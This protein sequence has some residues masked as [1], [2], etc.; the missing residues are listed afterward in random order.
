M[1]S[2]P[3]SMQVAKGYNAM[4]DI[5][6]LLGIHGAKENGEIDSMEYLDNT[7]GTSDPGKREEY[8]FRVVEDSL[9]EIVEFP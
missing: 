1:G 9:V 8:H 5:F 6:R 3:Q 4:L 7:L 2:I